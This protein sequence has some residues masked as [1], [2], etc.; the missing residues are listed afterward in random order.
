MLPSSCC[1]LTAAGSLR[2]TVIRRVTIFF[3]QSVEDQ[4]HY[5][6]LQ[7]YKTLFY[8]S[9]ARKK[10]EAVRL[11]DQWSARSVDVDERVSCWCVNVYHV[12]DVWFHTVGGIR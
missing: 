6:A 2:I 3:A 1:E 12:G 9:A 4:R 5:E 11:S 10:T 8:R 7:Q